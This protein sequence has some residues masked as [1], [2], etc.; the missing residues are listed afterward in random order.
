MLEPTQQEEKAPQPVE[1]QEEATNELPAETSPRE[2]VRLGLLR[3]N[4]P[5]E[6]V[7]TAIGPKT[8]LSVLTFFAGDTG[9]AILKRLA[10]LNIDPQGGGTEAVAEESTQEATLAGKTFVLTGTL[11]SMDRE[12]ASAKI[13][14]KGGAVASSV[15]RNTTYLVAGANTGARKTEK[16]AQL[17]VQVIDEEAFLAMLQ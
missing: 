11:A 15:S 14:A 13:R 3:E 12:T 10:E 9:K 7:T 8:A 6:Y 16:A 4:K 17:G 2:L 5:G 1:N